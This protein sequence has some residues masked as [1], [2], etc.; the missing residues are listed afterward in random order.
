MFYTFLSMEVAKLR[1]N[2]FR[3]K[4]GS[5]LVK[6]RKKGL[7]VSVNRDRGVKLG[8]DL[9]DLGPF[10]LSSWVT[11]GQIKRINSIDFGVNAAIPGEGGNHHRRRQ[12]GCD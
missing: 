10:L 2:L 5:S 6:W 7:C 8:S 3:N 12:G 11:W 4:P 9:I 1:S